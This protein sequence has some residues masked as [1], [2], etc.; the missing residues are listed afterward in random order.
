MKLLSTAESN[1]KLIKSIGYGYLVSGLS[2]RPADLSGFNVCPW[3]T[4][5]CK[6]AC[7]LEHAG[8]GNMP[9]V[10]DARDRKTVRLFEDRQGFLADLHKDL[11]ALERRAE[12]LGLVALVRLNVASDIAWERIDSTIF[13]AHPAIKFYD[14]TKGAK[15]L[16]DTLPA[17]YHLTYSY[18][19]ESDPVVV[20]TLLGQGYNVAMVFD[21]EYNPSHGKVG[22]L[23]ETKGSFNVV[24]GDKHDIRL[25][26]T[27]GHGVIVGLRGKGGKAIVLEGVRG[28]FIQPTIGGVAALAMGA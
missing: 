7:V 25:P 27:D 17:N 19:E 8:R 20:D 26:E 24:D 22:A 6:A 11:G 18:S 21:T 10:R 15:R 2:L 4:K 3:A 12:K 28:G 9:N 16:N 14:Y 13:T 1:R 23:P 5:S